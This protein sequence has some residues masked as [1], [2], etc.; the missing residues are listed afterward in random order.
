MAVSVEHLWST[1][2]TGGVP[3]RVQ[4]D[5]CV[6][7]VPGG[8]SLAQSFT[9]GGS[10]CHVCKRFEGAPL[11]IGCTYSIWVMQWVRSLRVKPQSKPRSHDDGCMVLADGILIFGVLTP[12][13]GIRSVICPRYRDNIIQM[14]DTGCFL[15]SVAVDLGP[16]VCGG[17][18]KLGPS[19]S[20]QA[21]GTAHRLLRLS[22][23]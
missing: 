11:V 1:D 9:K 5:L 20:R 22:R 14:D 3:V 12:P 13:S 18:R 6:D 15:Q 21:N 2:P 8:D 23:F 17:S 7:K 19:R 16:G 10:G 4:D